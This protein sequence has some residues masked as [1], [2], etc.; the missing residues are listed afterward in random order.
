MNHEGYRGLPEKLKKISEQIPN[1]DLKQELQVCSDWANALIQ[2][3]DQASTEA[4]DRQ[5]QLNQNAK[6]FQ[7]IDHLIDLNKP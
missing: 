5:R 7:M 3:V 2:D 1:P 4:Q 6:T